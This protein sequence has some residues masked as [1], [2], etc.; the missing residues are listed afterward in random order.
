MATAAGF[1]A[2]RIGSMYGS[3]GSFAGED[4]QIP[5]ITVE[6]DHHEIVDTGEQL[7]QMEEAT[8]LAAEWTAKATRPVQEFS[9][10]DAISPKQSAVYSALEMGRSAGNL[11]IRAERVGPVSANPVLVVTRIDA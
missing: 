5:T 11:S 4:L 1:P 7:A 8:Q 10:Y 2:N 9:I 3:L 6:F